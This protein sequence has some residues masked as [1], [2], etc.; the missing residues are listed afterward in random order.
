[1]RLFLRTLRY[2]DF[3]GYIQVVEALGLSLMKL[4]LALSEIAVGCMYV[5]RDPRSFSSHYCP[6]HDR[7]GTDI[8]KDHA[9]S[10]G[11]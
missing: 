3:R 1:M 6:R 10:F 5:L 2:S 8:V 7:S 9:L 4:D 11:R